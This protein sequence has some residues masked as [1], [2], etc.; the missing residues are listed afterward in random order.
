MP[1]NRGTS[2]KGKPKKEMRSA[3][4]GKALQ[5]SQTKRYAPKSNGSSAHGQGM[6]A[7]GAA[8]I[9]IYEQPECAK[10]KSVL[11]MDDLSDFLLQAELANKDFQSEREQFLDI[12]AAATEYVPTGQTSTAIIHGDGRASSSSGPDRQFTF[13]EL[14]VPRRPRWTPGVTTPEELDAME[15]E[16]FL[17]WRR[18]LAQ[19][20]ERIAALAF[21]QSRH[22]AAV[23][24]AGGMIGASVTPYEKNLQVWRQL[25]RVLERSSVVVQIVDARNPLF[26]LSD[27]LRLYAEEELGK[28]TLVLVNKS[29]Y[30][31]EAQRRRWS[32]YLTGR[33]VDHLFFSAQQ[34]QRKIDEEI[35]RAKKGEEPWKD[36]GQGEEVVVSDG[37]DESDSRDDEND[38]GG[39]SPNSAG[40]DGMEG[41]GGMPPSGGLTPTPQEPDEPVQPDPIGEGVSLGVDRPLT[42][43]RL[44]NALDAFAESHGCVPDP[45]YD[46]RIQ[47]GMV[48][49]PNVGKSSVINVLV[50]SSRSLHGVARAAVASQPGKTKHFQ[51]LLLPDREDMMLCDCPGLVFPSFV[52]S[53]ADMVAAGVYPIAQ[54]RDHWPVVELICKRVPR[55]VLNAHYGIKL[56][57]PS[58]QELREMGWT[59]K[60][61]PPPT[62]E[63][64]LGTYCV[65][66]SIL[67]AASGVPDYQRASRVVVKDYGDGRLLYCH[68]PPR[69]D[70]G[71]ESSSMEVYEEEYGRET[72]KTAMLN[73]SNARKLRKLEE[74][75]EAAAAA[76]EKAELVD[77]DGEFD[78]F[79]GI[80]GDGGDGPNG[81][82]DK[83]GKSHKS[84]KKWGKKGRKLRNSD[85]YGCHSEPESVLQSSSAGAGVVVNAGKY[86]G[87]YTRANYA[88][89]KAATPFESSDRASGSRKG[90]R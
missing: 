23:S 4:F 61:L 13:K 55:D 68:A 9:G 18:A 27:D 51:T 54:M 76:A 82:G 73:T 53:A 28:P 35:A 49:F 57:E 44:L 11:E 36:R 77:K 83:R 41:D 30:L 38:D 64:L 50:A 17:E 66:R 7:T 15:I 37:D 45:K 52:S 87:S 43:E 72:L 32:E 46:D 62:A 34:E 29:D 22:N 8:N 59:S 19:H 74:S 20:E 67:A 70:G 12:D 81:N 25:W 42:R 3:G 78:D 63:E 47:Y 69:L 31:T 5:R 10:M 6:M 79:D 60:A 1:S 86:S 90:R 75:L 33:G 89:A 80:L 14:S 21:A 2:R 39:A 58:K 48:G 40:A 88:G 85:P 84:I 65:A 24:R 26:Y 71:G 56:P 16:S